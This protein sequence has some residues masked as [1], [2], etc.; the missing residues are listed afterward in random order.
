MKELDATEHS[1]VLIR[2]SDVALVWGLTGDQGPPQ[3]GLPM[4]TLDSIFMQ[5]RKSVPEEVFWEVLRV[6]QVYSPKKHFICGE[7]SPKL[8]TKAFVQHEYVVR[9]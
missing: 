1:Y 4:I 2:K 9:K 5:A 7:P 3:T 8:V 6:L